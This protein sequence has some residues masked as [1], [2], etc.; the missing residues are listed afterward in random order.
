MDF[1][2]KPNLENRSLKP[3]GLSIRLNQNPPFFSERTWA[4]FLL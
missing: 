2:G 4:T 3:M 1:N